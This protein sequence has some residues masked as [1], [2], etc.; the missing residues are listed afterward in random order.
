[1]ANGRRRSRPTAKELALLVGAGAEE[2][3]AIPPVLG[4][5]IPRRA[6]AV[7]PRY[8]PGEA[9]RRRLQLAFRRS[10]RTS[11]SKGLRDLDLAA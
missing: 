5:P 1:M 8:P 11:A 4:L 3:P 9:V 6:E 2:R 10:G 7:V